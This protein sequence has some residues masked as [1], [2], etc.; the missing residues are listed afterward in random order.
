MHDSDLHERAKVEMFNSG[1][2]IGAKI[3]IPSWP[4]RKALD[5]QKTHSRQRDLVDEEA[6]SD[7]RGSAEWQASRP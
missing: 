6:L 2:K 4:A 5:R 3:S 7:G 1:E